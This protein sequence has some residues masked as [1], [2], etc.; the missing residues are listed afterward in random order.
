MGRLEHR[1]ASMIFTSNVPRCSKIPRENPWDHS[2]SS[3]AMPDGTPMPR[4]R[5]SPPADPG[6][7]AAR[8]WGSQE[9]LGARLVVGHP[10]M[11]LPNKWMVC[12]CLYPI[13]PGWF[14][15]GNTYSSSSGI[16]HE[17]HVLGASINGANQLLDAFSEGKSM[18]NKEDSGAPLFQGK[19]IFCRQ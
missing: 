16:L 10:Y 17:K 13:D 11:E 18:K 5:Y 9:Q 19:N 8:P 1:Y 15:D 12:T 4:S 6:R 7:G 2:R 3:P 14:I